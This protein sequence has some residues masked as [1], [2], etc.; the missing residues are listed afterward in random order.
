M[1]LNL[2]SQP[3][4]SPK[5][6][7]GYV[8]GG[9]A[10][11]IL[12]ME[13]ATGLGQAYEHVDIFH[14]SQGGAVRFG[15]LGTPTYGPFLLLQGRRGFPAT[16]SAYL[17]TSG[18]YIGPI[19]S[20]YPS[21][22]TNLE[23][24]GAFQWGSGAAKS[25]GT[26]SGALTMASGAGIYM[27]TGITAQS[28]SAQPLDYYLSNLSGN[29]ELGLYSNG[30]GFFSRVRFGH[31]T[32]THGSIYSL[33][34]NDGFTV[35]GGLAGS[36]SLKLYSNGGAASVAQGIGL[37]PGG[38]GGT[39]L[40]NSTGTCM[41]CGA[42]SAVTRLDVEGAAQFGGGATKSTVTAS[43]A[44]TLAA[45]AGLTLSGAS[46]FINTQS[47][48]NASA[49]FGDGSHL[50][51]VPMSPQTLAALEDVAASTAALESAKVD[52]AGDTMTGALT[53][54][55]ASVTASAF[56]GDGSHL[57]GMVIS[58]Y[59]AVP[60]TVLTNT[61]FGVCF[62]TVTLMTTAGATL[63]ITYQG[64]AS[65]SNPGQEVLVSVLMDGAFIH[66][67]T[68]G[69][70]AAGNSASA[71]DHDNVGFV[72]EHSLEESASGTHSFCLTARVTANTGTLHND[73]NYFSRFGVREYR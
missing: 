46:A 19:P 12:S 29:S 39:V 3:N 65:N 11:N 64:I 13:T 15:G 54:S 23:V 52:R 69:A 60:N 48:V 66:T 49:F 25:T 41:G 24:N 8:S 58:S 30:G 16:N 63:S 61:A 26:S 47:S 10:T 17:N 67:P 73:A 37:I 40:V 68:I 62:A 7:L 21:P 57:T 1:L 44:L 70:L 55:G 28:S 33:G 31:G 27:S 6:N 51:D 42:R 56:F 9:A 22:S 5:I 38:T 43:G 71:N 72:H 59:T 45:D 20:S 32:A 14:G 50:T 36:A 2:Y 53:V 18:M 4:S 35:A 34:N